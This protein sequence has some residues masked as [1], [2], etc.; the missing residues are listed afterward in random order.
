MEGGGGEAV[1][2]RLQFWRGEEK[3]LLSPGAQLQ[4]EQNQGSVTKQPLN[5]D[6]FNSF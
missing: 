5:S 2:G 4:A 1:G 3:L 6:S